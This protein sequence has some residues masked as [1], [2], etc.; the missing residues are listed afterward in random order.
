M[1][2]WLRKS[3][4]GPEED[5]RP[6]EYSVMGIPVSCPHCKSGHFAFGT[7]RA[8]IIQGPQADTLAGTPLFYILTCT[9]CG[10]VDHFA[11]RPERG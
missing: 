10:H 9:K 3:L 4:V 5:I 8:R 11:K 6:G 2:Q 1:F 7:L